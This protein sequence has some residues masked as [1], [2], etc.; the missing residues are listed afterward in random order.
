[1]NMKT[2]LKFQHS[3]WFHCVTFSLTLQ[4]QLRLDSTRLACL[5][6]IAL[7]RIYVHFVV[8]SISWIA[9]FHAN[10]FSMLIACS[11][12]HG[13]VQQ[14]FS[15]LLSSRGKKT[16][17]SINGETKLDARDIKNQLISCQ[18]LSRRKPM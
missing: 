10:G 15:S 8:F 2:M 11:E 13:N 3:D 9:K 16:Q 6:L 5:K 17:N 12:H 18:T 1:M 14:G 4:L 7:I